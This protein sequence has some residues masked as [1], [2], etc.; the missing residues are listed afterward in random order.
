[1]ILKKKYLNINI[2]KIVNIIILLLNKYKLSI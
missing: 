1:M 2:K